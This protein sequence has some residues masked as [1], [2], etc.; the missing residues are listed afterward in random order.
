[1][2]S[3]WTDTLAR[4][5][6]RDGF[7][8]V[9]GLWSADEVAVL[10]RSFDRLVAL[11]AELAPRLPVDGSPAALLHHGAQFV[12]SRATPA[13]R[14]HRVVWCGAA[15]PDLLA[16]SADPRM[17]ALAAGALNHD[18]FD[19]LINQAHFKLPGDAVHFPWHQ[20]SVHRRYGTPLWTDVDGTGSY[21]Q[22]AIALDPVGP[23][24]G[25]LAF[26]PGSHKHGHI[27]PG[28]D[29][30]LPLD[31][32]DLSAAIAP[33]LAP[34]DVVLFGPYTVHGSAPNVS[35]QPRRVLVNGYASPGANRRV[36]PGEGSGRR[37]RAP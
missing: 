10:L 35:T 27:A 33:A 14:I 18:S 36:Y 16:A 23:D 15:Q 11:A 29:G 37:L 19:Q 22:V 34:G 12:L 30:E 17:R 2:R 28:V 31:R 24:N 21:V 20:D 6:H 9:R 25:P 7:A 13:P 32:F 4:D 5:W 8:V 1:M 26:L 3:P